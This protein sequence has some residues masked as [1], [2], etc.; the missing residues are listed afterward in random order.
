MTFDFNRTLA[1][2]FALDVIHLWNAPAV[3]VEY[4][5]AEVECPELRQAAYL[6]AF[7]EVRRLAPTR[8][9]PW[10]AAFAAL[11]AC[12]KVARPDLAGPCAINA[13]GL[14]KVDLTDRLHV[15]NEMEAAQ[16]EFT[17]T[18]LEKC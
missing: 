9:A 17:K 11:H 5:A 3:A 14:T 13:A 4:L 8:G 10:A 15:W 18:L 6:A 1:R 7:A 2:K 12:A 16:K